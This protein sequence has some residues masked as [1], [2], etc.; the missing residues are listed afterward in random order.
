[1][2]HATYYMLHKV[3]AV[4]TLRLEGWP[5]AEPRGF[6]ILG[7]RAPKVD[8]HMSYSQYYWLAKRTWILQKD[9][10]RGLNVIPI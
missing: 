7:C 3:D 1:M 6:N 4:S 5:L 2:L 8:P 9:F 10:N